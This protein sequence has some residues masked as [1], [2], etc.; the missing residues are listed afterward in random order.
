MTKNIRMEPVK[1]GDR[2]AL[3]PAGRVSFPHVFEAWSGNAKIDPSYSVNLLIDKDD[4]GMAIF[5]EV[6]QAA[7]MA[8]LEWKGRRPEHF[9]TP[10]GDGDREA[11]K[12]PEYAGKWVIKF[13]HKFTQ[14]LA[15]DRNK[16][17]I[18]DA[19]EIYGG[20]WARVKFEARPYEFAGNCGVTYSFQVL[21]KLADVEDDARYGGDGLPT[22]DGIPDV[23]GSVPGGGY[24]GGQSD[25]YGGPEQRRQNS[26]AAQAPANGG[27]YSDWDDVPF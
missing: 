24:G 9:R 22:T 1:I 17:E 2:I 12:Y 27:D 23:P 7:I 16:A 5:K 21:Q 3:T 11:D 18:V 13:S 14:P 4:P 19:R 6:N 20:C 15:I 8:K 25:G 26:Q 10:I